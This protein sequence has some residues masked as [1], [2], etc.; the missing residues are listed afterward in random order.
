M[1]D[2]SLTRTMIAEH[3]YPTPTRNHLSMHNREAAKV[4]DG[5]KTRASEVSIGYRCEDGTSIMFGTATQR[6]EARRM[7]LEDKALERKQR[8]EALVKMVHD[9]MAETD[10]WAH[11][12]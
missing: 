11:K 6:A 12:S 10:S 3:S 7:E 2:L 9:Q 1:P 8:S 4:R 5:R